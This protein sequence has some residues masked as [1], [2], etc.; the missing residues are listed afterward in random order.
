MACYLLLL[1][2]VFCL[3]FLYACKHEYSAVLKHALEK[4]VEY[5]Y[6][7]FRR[8]QREQ[9]VDDINSWNELRET[10]FLHSKL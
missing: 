1:F 3:F 9:L 8:K 10:I 6:P 2:T 5:G 4:L 7:S